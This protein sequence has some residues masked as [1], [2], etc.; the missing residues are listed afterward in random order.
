M[1]KMK[2]Q[3]WKVSIMIIFHKAISTLGMLSYNTLSLTDANL[4]I[5]CGLL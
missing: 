4:S 5:P 2:M 1:G 3:L